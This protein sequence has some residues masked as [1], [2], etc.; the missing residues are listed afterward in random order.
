MVFFSSARFSLQNQPDM[1]MRGHVKLEARW[2]VS[3]VLTPCKGA[4]GSM[5]RAVAQLEAYRNNVEQRV[6]AHFDNARKLQDLDAM[7]ACATIMSQMQQTSAKLV[8]VRSLAC[9]SEFSQLCPHSDRSVLEHH[10]HPSDIP[11][12]ETSFVIYAR[13]AAKVNAQQHQASV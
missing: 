10:T 4:Q 6:V 3:G 12:P 8:T 2:S 1:I 9:T 13:F 7:A 5:A 11:L